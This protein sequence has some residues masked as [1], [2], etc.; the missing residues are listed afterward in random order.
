MEI[1][2]TDFVCEDLFMVWNRLNSMEMYESEWNYN[3]MW[4]VW[5]RL[6]SMEICLCI[7]K[8]TF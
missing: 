2:K 7:V 8:V 3:H 5:N 1:E 4:S 6:N